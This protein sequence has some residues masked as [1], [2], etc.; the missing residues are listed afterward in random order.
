MLE[1]TMF[2]NS[3]LSTIKNAE[4]ANH[5]EKAK[6]SIYALDRQALEAAYHV[7]C[8]KPLLKGQDELPQDFAEFMEYAFSVKRA[9]AFNILAIGEDVEK[10]TDPE[11][12]TDYFIDTYTL[13]SILKS[14]ERDENG[15]VK[16]WKAYLD[17]VKRTRTLG[18]TQILTIHRAMS[19]RAIDT[20]DIVTLIDKGAILPTMTISALDALLKG[21][22]NALET[23]PKT[24]SKT[25]SKTPDNK[26][27]DNKTPDNKTDERTYLE[28]PTATLKAAYPVIARFAEESKELA[29]LL[30]ILT[31]F[32]ELSGKETKTEETKTE[33]TKAEETKTEETKKTKK[34]K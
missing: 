29:A 12:N 26:T 8:I 31:G 18:K 32:K 24:N 7:A 27:P 14:C 25:N 9:Q 21:K 4:I 33:E 15:A 22:F 1:I 5:I 19:T 30:H 10:V 20:D 16:D 34:T 2:E 17:K 23:K 6:E 13:N 11:T 28:I 3:K